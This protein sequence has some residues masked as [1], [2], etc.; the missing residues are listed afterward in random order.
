MTPG[1]SCLLIFLSFSRVNNVTHP[2]FD[3]LCLYHFNHLAQFYLFSSFLLCS[4]FSTIVRLWPPVFFLEFSVLRLLFWITHWRRNSPFSC[5][6]FWPYFLYCVPEE[7]T[8][9]GFEAASFEAETQSLLLEVLASFLPRLA[10]AFHFHSFFFS[11]LDLL[12]MIYHPLILYSL[13][14][15]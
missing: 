9:S 10:I 14:T 15:A 12:T 2:F 13:D 3:I 8:L 1:S 5:L 11:F 4:S 6:I 7:A